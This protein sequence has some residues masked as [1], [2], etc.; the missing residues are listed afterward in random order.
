MKNLLFIAILLTLLV[1]S[2]CATL[3]TGTKDTITFNSTPQGAIVYK[4]GLELCSTP[5]RVPVKRS[6][7]RSEIEFQLDGYE[8][9]YITLDKE[10]NFV[11]VINL[12]NMFGWAVD[13]ATGSLVKYSNKS[14]DLTMKLASVSHSP[15]LTE[16]HINT[17]RNLVN[18]YAIQN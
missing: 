17:H 10:M 12:G 6:L 7:N 1:T 16:I 11:S 13:A 15:N 9:R 5:C 18:I 3:L 2:G 4:D 14:Y 8:T